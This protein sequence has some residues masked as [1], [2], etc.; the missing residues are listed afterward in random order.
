VVSTSSSSLRRRSG[1]GARVGAKVGAAVGWPDASFE[2]Q[3]SQQLQTTSGGEPEQSARKTND[4]KASISQK[5]VSRF[6]VNSVYPTTT[7]EEI[8]CKTEVPTML[9]CP[10]PNWIW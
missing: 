6:P 10:T 9:L 1:V 7:V 5:I 8:N 3:F 4:E 2:A